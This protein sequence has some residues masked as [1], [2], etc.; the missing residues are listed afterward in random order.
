VVLNLV[1]RWCCASKKHHLETAPKTLDERE[2]VMTVKREHLEALEHDLILAVDWAR[3]FLATEVEG[4]Y[5]S[6]AALQ[7]AL[8]ALAVAQPEPLKHI[9]RVIP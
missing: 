8:Y 6:D 2:T 3:E 4:Q 5:T 1:L 7:L 9:D